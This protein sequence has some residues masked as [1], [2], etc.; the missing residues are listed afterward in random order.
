M[1]Q[2][3]DSKHHPELSHGWSTKVAS[4]LRNE[5]VLQDD[6]ATQHVTL[7]DAV[8]HSTGMA[9]HDASSHSIWDGN[10]VY[11]L[12]VVRGLRHL[13]MRSEPRTTYEYCNAMYVTLGCILEKMSGKWLGAVLRDVIWKP[14]GMTSTFFD[15]DDALDSSHHFA[16]GYLW[17][18]DT[19][20]YETIPRMNVTSEG[21]AGAVLSNV[22]DY[23][24]WVQCLLG[25]T[26]PLSASVHED[27]RTPRFLKSGRAAGG[28]DA[29]SYGLGWERSTIYGHEV[30]KHSGGMHAYGAYVY[31]LPELNYGFVSFANTAVSS[32]AVEMILFARLIADKLRIPT[33]ERFD[34]EKEYVPSGLEPR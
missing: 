20:E 26:A 14:L 22:V 19:Q 33:H 29:T 23:A 9:G 24:K 27:I 30:C 7:N 8:S 21:G 11:P 31:W 12:D 32:N 5:F 15:L 3:I 17:N 28:F 2:F 4:L 18:R 13:P 16:D 6:W 34:I 1:A 10:A 25:K